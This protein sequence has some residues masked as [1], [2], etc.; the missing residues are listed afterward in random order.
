MHRLHH[1]VDHVIA[2]TLEEAEE[3][4]TFTGRLAGAP[5][6][7]EEK[8][9]RVLAYAREHDVDLATSHAYGDSAADLPMLECVGRAGTAHARYFAVKTR[10]N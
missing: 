2:N 4:E 7:D 10:F 1:G 8:R 5:V 9:T 6:A 3:T